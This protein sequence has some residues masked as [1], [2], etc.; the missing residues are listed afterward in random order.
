MHEELTVGLDD[1]DGGAGIDLLKC[2]LN[3]GGEGGVQ[4]FAGGSGQGGLHFLPT[5]DA[6]GGECHG[7]DVI[8]ASVGDDFRDG[9]AVVMGSGLCVGLCQTGGELVEAL[10][11]VPGKNGV[12]GAGEEDL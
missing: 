2:A 8:A 9:A 6:H 4:V 11:L 7:I 3:G 1:S 5:S 12:E 10:F